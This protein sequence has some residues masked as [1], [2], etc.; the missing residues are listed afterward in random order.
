MDN[1]EWVPAVA[2]LLGAL[3]MM[4]WRFWKSRKQ[5]E[6][7]DPVKFFRTLTVVAA[8]MSVETWAS[9]RDY[10]TV[11][12]PGILYV[13]VASFAAGWGAVMGTSEAVKA[14]KGE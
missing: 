10:L 3:S 2:T 14:V 12:G 4:G 6:A 11:Q 9:Y 7:F 8:L 13:V 1:I 5:G